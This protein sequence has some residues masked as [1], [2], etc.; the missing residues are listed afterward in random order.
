MTNGLE[1][2]EKRERRFFFFVI[3]FERKQNVMHMEMNFISTTMVKSLFEINFPSL[4]LLRDGKKIRENNV[5]IRSL[6]ES[7]I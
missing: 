4:I 2:Q 5:S 6:E 7:F 1:F 3:S